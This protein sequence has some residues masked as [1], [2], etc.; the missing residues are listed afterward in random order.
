MRKKP[1]LET[2]KRE[3]AQPPKTRKAQASTEISDAPSKLFEELAHV[4]ARVIQPESVYSIFVQ[5]STEKYHDHL[6]LLTRLFFAIASP[7]AFDQLSEACTITRQKNGP[8]I[9]DSL[10]DVLQTMHALD[11]L[12]AATSLTSILRRFQLA[13]LLDH[14]IGR[15][16][17]YKTQRP[18]RPIRRHKYSQE[19]LD[20]VTGAVTEPDRPNQP[21]R[22]GRAN[23]KAL[24]DLMTDF[25][26]RLQRPEKSTSAATDAEYWEKHKKLKNRLSCA[27]P[28]YLLQQ[29]FSP[30][31]LALVPCGDGHVPTDR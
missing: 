31:I 22:S 23:T 19:R 14:R 1:H 18:L 11:T 13:R 15:E 4:P 12:D 6:P 9:L 21:E 26:P 27:R 7:D 25:Y 16:Y 17:H 10:N 20:M 5:R 8:K 29:R 24:I 3:A 28:W 2:P 30:G